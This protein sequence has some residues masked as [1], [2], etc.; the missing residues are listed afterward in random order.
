[1]RLN[2][3]SVEWRPFWLGENELIAKM[4][5]AGCASHQEAAEWWSSL[6]EGQTYSVWSGTASDTPDPGSERSVN[7]VVEL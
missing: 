3:S 1:M 4:I 6:Q 5:I 7:N 2:M